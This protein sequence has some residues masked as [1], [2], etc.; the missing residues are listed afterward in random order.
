MEKFLIADVPLTQRVL[1]RLSGFEPT[2][3]EA[4]Q[5]IEQFIA[6]DVWSLLPRAST[7]LVFPGRGAEI[8][9]SGLPDSWLVQWKWASVYAKR[10]WELGQSPRVSVGH[11]FPDG[12]HLELTNVVII[13]DVV[14]SGLTC[15]KLMIINNPWFPRARWHITTWVMQRAASL[16]GFEIIRAV[17]SVGTKETKTSVQSLSTLLLDKEIASGY[18]ERHIANKS[19]FLDLL[20]ELRASMGVT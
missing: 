8:V 14:S 19:G 16:R 10:D 12:L 18:I 9:R 3:L 11:I 5:I 20:E 1:S 15:K 6:F 17:C 7:L 4:G 2:I 13:D